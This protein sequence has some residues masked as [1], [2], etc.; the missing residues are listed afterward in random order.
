MNLKFYLEKLHASEEYKNFMR[1]NPKAYLCSGFFIIDKVGNDEKKHFDYFIPISFP[2]P[3]PKD[4]LSQTRDIDNKLLTEN[5]EVNKNLAR[6]SGKADFRAINSEH[7][8]GKLFSF[9]F[10]ETIKLIPVELT[11]NE[12]PEKI[13]DN[14]NF[15]F[16]EVEKII[17]ERIE[18]ENIK[19]K[20]QKILLSLQSKNGKCFLVGTIFISSLGMIK[21]KIDLEDMNL[22]DFEKKSFM[23]MFKV[24]KGK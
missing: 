7:S 14:C 21:V 16:E 19:N 24:V 20:I 13:P 11:Y 6:K 22:I 9:Q 10:E 17:N 2:P 3:Q 15:Y 12:I 4:S 8:E 5:F 1:E 23:D 18:Q